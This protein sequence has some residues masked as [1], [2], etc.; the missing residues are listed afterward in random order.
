M[1]CS[2][3]T[4]Y[5]RRR[6]RWA[7]HPAH[8]Q[9]PAAPCGA[10]RAA[11]RL[12]RRGTS[13]DGA[14]TAAPARRAFV[15]RSGTCD[16]GAVASLPSVAAGFGA[17]ACSGGGVEAAARWKRPVVSPLRRA[18]RRPA[19]SVAGGITAPAAAEPAARQA[20]VPAGARRTRAGGAAARVQHRPRSPRSVTARPLAARRPPPA[21]RRPAP[22]AADPAP[23]AGRRRR[24]PAAHRWPPA[25]GLAIIHVLGS[26]GVAPS[27]WLTASRK[28]YR[29]SPWIIYRL[30][31]GS[32][33]HLPNR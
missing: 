30:Q 5:A 29:S 1:R 21:P 8:G 6:P 4:R 33:H 2:T 16:Q 23:A 14:S 18:V 10:D 3:T 15:A 20:T 17:A 31:S 28:V 9:N 13:C 32:I 12:A 24:R 25:P 19:S 22:S 26:V 27:W 11:G 7:H